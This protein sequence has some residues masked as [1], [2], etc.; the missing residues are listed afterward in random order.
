MLRWLWLAVP[1]VG[2]AELGAHQYFA[3]RAPTPAEWET[4]KPALLGLRKQD[5]LVVTAPYWAEPLARHAF[6]NEAFPVAQVSR[7]DESAFPRA[8]EV[9][10]LGARSPELG[11]WRLV[12]ERRHGGF[13]LRVLENPAPARVRFDFWSGLGPGQTEVAVD[14]PGGRHAC[15]YTDRGAGSTGGLHGHIAFPAA[16][17]QCPFGSEIFVG[18]TIVDDQ[19]YRPRRCL[20]AHPPREAVLVLTY[21]KVPL[22]QVVRGYGALSWFLWRD[23]GN[24]PV[25]L[26]VRV[27]GKSI[28]TFVHRDEEG[29]HGFE[30]PTGASAGKSATVEFRVRSERPEN[31]E[32]C[33]WADTR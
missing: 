15:L 11:S 7:P 9:S 19:N 29:W 3:H 25:E 6:G 1:L 20:W 24:S 31:R 17:F 32:F 30:F 10:I 16:R 13:R 18:Q 14:A 28:G 22:G 2:L 23:G 5:E 8:I 4:V 21:P 12:E 27:D 33:F 26:E